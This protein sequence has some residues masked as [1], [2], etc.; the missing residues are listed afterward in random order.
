MENDIDPMRT[1]P[2]TVPTVTVVRRNLPQ[3]EDSTTPPTPTGN[4]MPGS[5]RTPRHTL[6]KLRPRPNTHSLNPASVQIRKC[7]VDIRRDLPKTYTSSSR[8]GL[9]LQESFRR[10]FGV[11][12]RKK[13]DDPDTRRTLKVELKKHLVEEISHATFISINPPS[14]T[15]QRSHRCECYLHKYFHADVRLTFP[16]C[17][18]QHHHRDHDVSRAS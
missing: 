10:Q 15:K 18:L 9:A 12:W 11:W 6:R 8:I 1:A 2:T 4:S 14:E 7:R 16:D 17:Y 3:Q 5:P 13:Y